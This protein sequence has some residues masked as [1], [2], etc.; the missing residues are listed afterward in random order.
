MMIAEEEHP[1]VPFILL[2]HSMGSF[3]AQQCVIHRS[4]LI[5]GLALSGSNRDEVHAN[6]RKWVSAVLGQTNITAQ[7][8]SRMYGVRLKGNS[9][10]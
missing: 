5:D 9:A 4:E 3:D 6:L 7:R 8:S 1:E 10:A 2:G